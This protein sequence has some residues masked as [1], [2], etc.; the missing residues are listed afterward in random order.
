MGADEGSRA[1]KDEAV[2]C[3]P[4]QEDGRGTRYFLGCIG[5]LQQPFVGSGGWDFAGMGLTRIGHVWQWL[6]STNFSGY[7]RVN[8]EW[9]CVSVLDVCPMRGCLLSGAAPLLPAYRCFFFV[10]VTGKIT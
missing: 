4:F 9:R 2:F 1:E 3:R 7:L 8:S 6:V 10:A 5:A